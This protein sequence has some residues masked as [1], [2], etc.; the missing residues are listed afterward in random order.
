MAVTQGIRKWLLIGGL[1]VGALFNG[2]LMSPVQAAVPQVYIN[3]TV[4][5]INVAPVNQQGVLQVPAKELAVALG[6]S[7]SFDAATNQGTLK[8][9]DDETVFLLNS[10]TVTFN[11]K[12]ITAPAPMVMANNRFMIPA[13][14][15]C[16]TLGLVSVANGDLL[17]VYKPVNG[18]ITYAVMSGDTL[19]RI[20]QKFGTTIA[21]IQTLNGLTSDSLY[22]GQNL[23]IQP[24]L[25]PA[26][27]V[28]AFMSSSG[29]CFSSPSFSA[30]ALGYL[31][32]GT[33]LPV[34]GKTGDWYKVQS[35]FGV[36]YVYR[37][38]LRINQTITPAPTPANV[39]DANIP[40][41]TSGDR[42]TYKSYTV[43]SGDTV[44]TIAEKSGIL[45]DELC[46][47]N[48]LGDGSNLKVG[49]VLKIPVHTIAPQPV[50]GPQ[51]G[52]VLDWFSQGQ[53]VFSIGKVGKLVDLDTG[54]SFMIQ[55]TMGANHADVETL[56]AADTQAMKEIFGGFT[57]NRRAFVLYVDGRKFAVSVAGMPHAGV[58]SAPYL[59]NVSW[60][61]GNYGAGPNYDRIKGN[62]M[63]GHFDV[64]TL[65][66]IGHAEPTVSAAHQ[67]TVLMAGGLE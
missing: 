23:S 37:S 46:A 35:G 19:W 8:T 6:G 3:N 11:G 12:Y 57:W 15:L 28:T 50:L 14:F 40:V 36:G 60:R 38:V 25:S 2:S 4:L 47:V 17:Q 59:A 41:D 10:P 66:S 62:G 24:Q 20:S 51:Y 26:V 55:R 21:S 18:R 31:Q 30:S 9:G 27:S 32:P 63:D 29:T 49:Q 1:T 54:R 7:F 65:N 39:F 58:D 53:Y 44:W 43:V 45:K 48:G 67:V 61:S 5:T 56:T 33:T 52:E 64:Y 22:V 42:L 34:L 16:D 13:D